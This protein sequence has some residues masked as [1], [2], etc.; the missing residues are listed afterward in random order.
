M[1][2]ISFPNTNKTNAKRRGS[3]LEGLAAELDPCSILCWCFYFRLKQNVQIIH[4]GLTRLIEAGKFFPRK[5]LTKQVLC[6]DVWWKSLGPICYNVRRLGKICFGSFFLF[7]S[8]INLDLIL[9]ILVDFYYE[10]VNQVSV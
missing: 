10:Q 8:C 4:F 3:L 6:L 1:I 2:C 7:K 9:K 5:R